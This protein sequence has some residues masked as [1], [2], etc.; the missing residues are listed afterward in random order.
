VWPKHSY[1]HAIAKALFKEPLGQRYYYL[2]HISLLSVSFKGRA[3][4]VIQNKVRSKEAK[5]CEEKNDYSD[6]KR[7]STS[8]PLL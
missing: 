7:N 4:K 5:D 1:K 3:T 6:S 2:S 8:V